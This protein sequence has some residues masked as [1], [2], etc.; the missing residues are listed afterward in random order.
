MQ[1]L[2]GK[3]IRLRALEVND[4]AFLY[5]IENNEDY[6]EVSNT[7]KP[8][9]YHLLRQYLANAHQDIYE[10][11]QLRLVIVTLDNEAI[12]FIDLFDFDPHH[13]R[14]GIG[15]LIAHEHQGQ[16]YASEALTLLIN[17]AFTHLFL[18]QIYANITV[19]NIKSINLFRKKGFEKIGIKRDWVA[20]QDGYKDEL[21]FQLIKK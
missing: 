8:F 4:L 15:I 2:E 6:W 21:M 10:A 5:R 14:A 17:Y 19:D 18:H 11:K 9:S 13:R 3:N 12:G 16:G 1:T 20:T 7:Y